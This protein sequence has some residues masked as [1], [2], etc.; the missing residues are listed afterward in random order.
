MQKFS[1][2]LEEEFLAESLKS[3]VEFYMTDDTKLPREIYAAFDFDGT[4]YGLSLIE[5]EYDRVYMLDFYRVVNVK[6]RFWSFTK[7]NHIRTCLST[8]IKFMEAC[9]PFVQNRM[10]GIIIDIPGKTGSEKYTTFME[11]LIKRSYVKKYRSVPVVKTTDKARNYLFAVKIG[12]EPTS[13]F[14]TAT[15]HKNFKFNAG[16]PI[17]TTDEMDQAKG[18]Y[19]TIKQTVSLQPSKKFA[20]GALEVELTADQETIDLLDAASEK[21][22]LQKAGK[23]VEPKQEKKTLV[24][25]DTSVAFKIMSSGGMDSFHIPVESDIGNNQNK[26]DLSYPHLMA[27]IFKDAFSKIKQYGY[28][29]A[30][31]NVSNTEYA[32]RQGFQLLPEKV[33]KSLIDSGLFLQNG[34]INLSSEYNTN[35][36]KDTFKVFQLMD[37]FEVNTFESA[38]QMK[39]PAETPQAS[40]ATSGKLKAN[41]VIKLDL[42]KTPVSV[43]PGFETSN[44]SY[45]LYFAQGMGFTESSEN[46][47][48]KLESIFAMPEVKKWFEKLDV[49]SPPGSYIYSYSG[50]GYMGVNDSLRYIIKNK[51]FKISQIQGYGDVTAEKLIDYFKSSAPTLS[52]GIWVYRNADIPDID[53]YD[54]GDDIIDPAFLSTSIRSSMSLGDSGNARLKIYVPKGTRCLPILTKSQHDQEHEIVFAPMSVLR[55][56]EITNVQHP[57]ENKIQRRI[58]CTM[59]GSAYESFY[60]AIKNEVQI[61]LTE[62]NSFGGFK[63]KKLDKIEKEEQDRN[64]KWLNMSSVKDSKFISNLIKIGKLKIK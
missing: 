10:H 32:S 64:N 46:V 13:L 56:T 24:S 6:K 31:F 21:H 20:F 26:I 52:N 5:S 42:D 47:K 54:V 34:M 53:K 11:R 35:L 12:V 27:V 50:S 25:I 8:V 51:Y 48:Q 63:D 23:I 62:Q 33:R 15:F 59:I 44:N 3:P 22:K 17:I 14:K 29:D 19:K 55:A 9:I 1:Q 61:E 60:E 57:F 4:T 43:V 37:Q 7:A 36:L 16:K 49:Y 28:D 41:E 39:V 18:Y 2:F 40:S 38:M 30:K 45:A 58:V